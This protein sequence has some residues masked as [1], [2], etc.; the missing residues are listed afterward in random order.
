MN[1]K[2]KSH[3]ALICGH[4]GSKNRM[5]V[6]ATA[7]D[8][9]EFEDDQGP[10]WESGTRYEIQKCPVCSKVVLVDGH[11]HDG[12][13]SAEEWIPR[14]LLPEAEDRDARN[15]YQRRVEDLKYMKM[16]VEE[17]SKSTPEGK[18]KPKVGAVVVTCDGRLVVPGHRGENNPG[19]HAEYTILE[20]KCQQQELA[21]ATVYT[22]LEP[23]TTRNAPKIPCATRLVNRKVARVVIGMLDPDERIRG[24]GVLLLRKANIQVDLFPPSLMTKLEEMNRDFISIKESLYNANQEQMSPIKRLLNLFR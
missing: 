10:C 22:T 3:E 12:M 11:W 5:D 2:N 7:K 8:T 9:E 1:E 23:C 6:I 4:C 19:E 20:K 14:V 21:A 15:F 17:A 24:R 13:E 16:A 18:D